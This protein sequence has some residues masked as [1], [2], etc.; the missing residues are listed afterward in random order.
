MAGSDRVVLVVM[1]EVRRRK[2]EFEELCASALDFSSC[3]AGLDSV[4]PATPG[5]EN[6]DPR[7]TQRLITALPRCSTQQSVTTMVQRV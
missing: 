2:R 3:G 6:Q 7:S 4:L 1:E 5:I